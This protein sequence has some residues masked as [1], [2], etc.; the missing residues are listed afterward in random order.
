MQKM[1][2]TW[3]RFQG[4][5]DSLEV[6]MA[7]HSSI[8]AWRILMARGAW[9]ATVHEVAKSWTW[10]MQFSTHTL[11]KSISNNLPW[12]CIWL[13]PKERRMHS[14]LATCNTFYIVF[15][16]YFSFDLTSQAFASLQSSS[17]RVGFLD[18][19]THLHNSCNAWHNVWH[20]ADLHMEKLSATE[21]D[22]CSQGLCINCS[23]SL[24]WHKWVTHLSDP[25]NQT[26]LLKCLHSYFLWWSGFRDSGSDLGRGRYRRSWW[27]SW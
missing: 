22:F 20:K 23:H 27:G 6:G 24:I 13:P 15:P 7:T 4:W 8:L 11:T 19:K 21:P 16:W 17:W 5:E 26:A 9:W 25:F 3:V 14:L 18:S 1:W 10:L 12:M 2:G